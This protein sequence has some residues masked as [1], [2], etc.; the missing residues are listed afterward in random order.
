MVAMAIEGKQQEESEMIHQRSRSLSVL[1]EN[2]GGKLVEDSSSPGPLASPT[3][4]HD[5]P[6]RKD[7][8]H[9]IEV[10]GDPFRQVDGGVGR[11]V[12]ERSVSHVGGV[13]DSWVLV[14]RR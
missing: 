13:W 12:V 2:D 10:C 5:G 4:H 9:S 11:V 1:T 14:K 6:N 8:R 3:R 7:S